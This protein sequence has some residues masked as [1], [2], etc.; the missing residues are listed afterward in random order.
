MKIDK[1]DI[2]EMEDGGIKPVNFDG[3]LPEGEYKSVIVD[4]IDCGDGFAGVKFELTGTVG[5]DGT[6]KQMW[7]K[8]KISGLE[9][10][11][12]GRDGIV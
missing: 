4:T 3:T 9:E 8:C 5:N 1:S 12:K 7:Q 2:D 6:P 11:V 10:F